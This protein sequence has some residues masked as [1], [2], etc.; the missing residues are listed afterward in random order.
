MVGQLTSYPS[1]PHPSQ[2]PPSVSIERLPQLCEDLR[3]RHQL[4]SNELMNLAEEEADKLEVK[5]IQGMRAVASSVECGSWRRE[6][7]AI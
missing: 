5:M 4:A 6:T 3:C 7:S 1:L 2:Q